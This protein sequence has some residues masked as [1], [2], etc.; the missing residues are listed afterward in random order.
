MVSRGLVAKNSTVDDTSRVRDVS[1]DDLRLEFQNVAVR[2][3]LP[4]ETIT[5]I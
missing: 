4:K 5:S 1:T 3:V 2:D